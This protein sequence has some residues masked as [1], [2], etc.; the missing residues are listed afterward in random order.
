[1][2]CSVFLNSYFHFGTIM[3]MK[4][5]LYCIC[6]CLTSVSLYALEYGHNE[7]LFNME[8]YYQKDHF[9]VNNYRPDFVPTDLLQAY[10][11]NIALNEEV[12]SIHIEIGDADWK[13]MMGHYLSEDR[14][15]NRLW[16]PVEVRLTHDGEVENIAGEIK[17]RGNYSSKSLKF[18]FRLKLEDKIDAGTF[19]GKKK[20]ITRHLTFDRTGTNEYVYFQ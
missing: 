17:H 9:V 11:K 12:K 5:L 7:V 19:A 10:V 3:N 4:R 18:G 20:I 6:L 13:D 2:R 1:M 8:N 16:Y 14:F 15:E